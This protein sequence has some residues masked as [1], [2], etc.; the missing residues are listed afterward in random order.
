MHFHTYKLMRDNAGIHQ[1][2]FD[3]RYSTD[4][5]GIAESLGLQA[6]PKVEL[7]EILKLIE[8]KLSNDTLFTPM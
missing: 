7:A 3:N 6:S 5:N 2:Q 4:S 8:S 1:L